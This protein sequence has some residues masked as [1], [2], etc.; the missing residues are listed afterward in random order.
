M[1]FY[2]EAVGAEDRLAGDRHERA[3]GVERDPNRHLALADLV[4]AGDA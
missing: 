1:S 2:A 4:D 3:F